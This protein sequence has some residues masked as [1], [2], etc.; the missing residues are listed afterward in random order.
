MSREYLRVPLVQRLEYLDAF[1]KSYSN[2]EF[3]EEN[4]KHAV[5]RQ[6][7]L[8]EVEKAKALGRKRPRMRKGTSTLLEC[9]NLSRHLGLI[10]QFKRL[11]PDAE[12]ALDTADRRPLLVSRMWQTYPRFRKVVLAVRDA[13]Q[14]ILP[15]YA[16]GKEFREEASSRY[17]FDFDRL[18]LETIRNLASQLELVNWYP[19]EQRKQIIYPVTSIVMLSEMVSLAGSSVRLDTYAQQQLHQT[20]LDLGLLRIRDDRYEVQASLPHEKQGYLIF[21]TESDRVFVRD[22]TI[23]L[24]NFEQIVW[25]EY[26]SLSDM[27]PRYPVLY[28]N[29]RNRVCAILR[30][31][32]RTF[33]RH[34][35]SLIRDPRRLNIYP[36][37]GVL[38]YAANFAHLGKFLPPKTAQ[39]N[40]IIYLKAERRTTA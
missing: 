34:L 14:L 6:I 16:R 20:A 36:S 8:V 3:D 29:L 38:D 22:H 27:R 17:G 5:Q 10:D 12:R 28:P 21:Q 19:T 31:P 39:G 24:E 13:E 2:V 9:L 33:D 26:L 15:F 18:T 1:L 23:S 30:I 25:Q 40:F 4:A 32:D 35:L 37:G 11:T 7:N